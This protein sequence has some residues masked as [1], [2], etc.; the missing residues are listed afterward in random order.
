MMRMHYYQFNIGD[1][2]SHT[3][4][5]SLIEDLAYR[6]LIDQYYLDERALN[7]CSTDVA[8]M[9]GMRDFSEDVDYILSRFFEKD[10]DDWNHSRINS[11]ILSF[12]DK[13]EK[14]SKAGKVS[15]RKR[16]EAKKSNE[17]STDAEQALSICTT[18]VQPTNNQEQSKDLFP[19]T[20]DEPS[21]EKLVLDYLKE[22][23]GRSFRSGQGLKQRLAEGHTVR[24]CQ[25]LIRYKS[26]E[27]MNTKDQKYLRPSTL[28]Q[29]S[30]FEGYLNDAKQQVSTNDEVKTETLHQTKEK[31]DCN[32]Q[33]LKSLIEGNAQ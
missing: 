4:G 17:R 18:D 23:T 29:P 10:G 9:I 5:L 19:A 16:A 20:P 25:M 14:N 6:R 22:C 33:R 2:A 30:K 26:Q 3:K 15:A 32:V 8:R 31:I 12:K 13:Q 28:F 27:W 24:D 7:G 21:A 11:E 1:Y